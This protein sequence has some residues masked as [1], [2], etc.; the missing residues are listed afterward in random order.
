MLDVITKIIRSIGSNLLLLFIMFTCPVIAQKDTQIMEIRHAYVHDKFNYDRDY[1]FSLLKLVLKSSEEEFGPFKLVTYPLNV[2]QKRALVEIEANQLDVTW[3]MTSL[4]RE[5]RLKPIRI[6]LLMGLAGYR[7]FLIRKGE[8]NRFDALE[9]ENEIKQFIAG[10][11]AYWPDTE[12]LLNNGYNVVKGI[13]H[14]TLFKRLRF[15]RFDYM[16]RSIHEIWSE[17]A[18]FDDLQVEQKFA[19]YYPSPFYFF[20]NKSNIKLH[21]RLEVGLKNAMENGSFKMLFDNHISTKSM[22]KNATLKSRKIFTLTNTLMTPE[23]KAIMLD[24]KSVYQP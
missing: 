21:K 24:Y 13:D 18:L 15:Q 12:I 19:F 11:G 8:Q 6:P 7:V 20:V 2:L 22:L 9:T 3:T 5:E 10:Q 16:P 17:V 4:E 14:E 1:F 23:T